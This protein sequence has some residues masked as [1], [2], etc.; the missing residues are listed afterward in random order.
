MSVGLDHPLV[1]AYLRRLDEAAVGLPAGRRGELVEEIRGHVADALLAVGDDE[2]AVRGVLDR[3]GSPEDIVA[4]E[5]EGGLASEPPGYVGAANPFAG[6]TYP[7]SHP[8]GSAY[9]PSSAPPAPYPSSPYPSGPTPTRTWG[10]VEIIAVVGLTIGAFVLPVIGPII[11]LVCAWVSTQWTRR[12]KIVATIWT[13]LMP[14]VIVLAGAAVFM[15]R[16]DTSSSTDQAPIIVDEP[17]QPMPSMQASP[18]MGVSP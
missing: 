4:A 8:S 13:A 18:S 7:S 12:E 17:A 2:P 14:L 5:R 1:A 6:H 16:A 11:G 3:L 9:P 10:P 15:V